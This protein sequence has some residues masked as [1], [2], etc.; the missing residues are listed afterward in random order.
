VKSLFSYNLLKSE[1]HNSKQ[2]QVPVSVKP[3]LHICS[4]S[5]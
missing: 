2:E 5:S 3:L 1:K 4:T